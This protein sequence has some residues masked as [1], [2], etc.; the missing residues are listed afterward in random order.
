MPKT[1][2]TITGEDQ[3]SKLEAIVDEQVEHA[4]DSH[5]EMLAFVDELKASL[6]TLVEKASEERETTT[7]LIYKTREEL[8]AFK[9]TI[10]QDHDS[11][12][13][14]E[15]ELD[16]LHDRLRDLEEQ[17]DTYQSRLDE[18][19]QHLEDKDRKL[20]EYEDRIAELEITLKQSETS[21]E[22]LEKAQARIA[23]LEKAL[24][25]QADAVE[26][27]QAAKRRMLEMETT[28]EEYASAAKKEHD[29]AQK[30]K[31]KFKALELS[32][33]E[34]SK[35]LGALEKQIQ[36]LQED[37]AL[38]AAEAEFERNRVADIEQLLETT[39][40]D[41]AQAVEDKEQTVRELEAQFAELKTELEA[42]EDAATELEDDLSKV[43]FELKG[44]RARARE[45]AE[46]DETTAKAL[47]LAREELATLNREI[48]PLRKLPDALEAAKLTLAAEQ[49]R[50][51]R[52]AAELEEEKSHGT[53]S[54]L[55]EQLAGALR[56]REE[57]MDTLKRLRKEFSRYKK[58]NPPSSKKKA[59]EPEPD[60]TVRPE[61]AAADAVPSGAAAVTALEEPID[62]SPRDLIHVAF[63][64]DEEKRR[65]GEILLESGV[66]T[67]NQLA[68]AVKTQSEGM[69]NERIGKIF[70][71]MG[72]AAE[73]V[74]AQALAYQMEGRFMRLEKGVV[75]K[76]AASKISGRLAAM[77]NC[78]PVEIDGHV[79]VV[80]MEN[81]L[82]LVAVE[83]LER[84]TN[85]RIE[86]VV[87][88]SKDIEW[89]LETY[90]KS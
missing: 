89:A 10:V 23:K 36:T 5:L 79:L 1:T 73:D 2:K 31:G 35:T 64:L 63:S 51:D 24:N 86:P 18:E 72:F 9:D 62:T 6:G 81:P 40:Q 43:M 33:S 28:V 41:A 76:E 75:S 22:G 15:S 78:V 65:L 4:E 87:A 69:D 20:T 14:L 67:Q 88:T 29:R 66:I 57:T 37:L 70:V 85:M 3:Y 19:K 17:N 46:Q 21:D 8:H 90:Y 38:R 42:A 45:S 27:G 84:T 58:I 26:A 49:E 71:S 25:Q 83:D 74:V 12:E 44:I 30:Y 56:D 77:H 48:E 61:Q 80:A 54:V 39:K 7:S 47:E 34:E 13:S 32:R 50:A 60:E 52:M 55:A 59:V 68:M 16:T 82:N 11:A 53:K